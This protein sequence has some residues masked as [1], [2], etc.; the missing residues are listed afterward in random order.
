MVT[1]GIGARYLDRYGLTDEMFRNVAVTFSMKD[2][3]TGKY[4]VANVG[5][6]IRDGEAMSGYRYVL[7]YMVTESQSSR[8]GRYTGEFRVD[9]LDT[10]AKITFPNDD[11]IMIIISDSI[12]KTTVI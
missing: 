6:S 7:E 8:P 11:G 5:G 10:G 9:F 1:Y 3:D 4:R 12:T 2:I